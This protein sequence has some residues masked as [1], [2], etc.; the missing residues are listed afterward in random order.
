MIHFQIP[1]NSTHLYEDIGCFFTE[2]IPPPPG[3]KQI[4]TPMKPVCSNSLSNYL[5][6]IKERIHLYEK[7]WDIYKRYTNPYEYIHTPIPSIYNHTDAK[8]FSNKYRGSNRSISKYKPLSRSYFKMIELTNFFRLLDIN[9]TSI[10]SIDAPISSFHLAEGPGGFIEALANMRDNKNDT[11]IGITILDDVYDPN[12]PAWKKSEYFL[13]ENPNVYIETGADKTG[14]ILSIAN[15]DYCVDKYGSSMDIIT[16]DGGFDFSVDFNSQEINI[17]RLLFAQVAYAICLQKQ[18]GSFILKIFDCFMQHTLDVLAILSSFYEKVY[19][20]KP[21]TS[22]YAN[23]EK[24]IVCKD[25]LFEPSNANNFIPIIRSAFEKMIDPM[26]VQYE[27]GRFLSVPLSNYFTTR[28]E[29]LNA[30]FGQQQIENIH[31]TISLID[32]KT[33]G[34]KLNALIKSNI[35]KC[36]VWCLKHNC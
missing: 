22:R 31:F 10:Q 21:Q 15:F 5:Y 2:S 32:C 16:G 25:F 3:F 8:S 4:V 20:T 1:R 28:V 19:I 34:E 7:E 29:E 12:I 23:S 27:I 33:R 17:S 30:I 13:K 24:Y 26:N 36:T 6:D 11:Y 14:D 9:E 35:E 18:K